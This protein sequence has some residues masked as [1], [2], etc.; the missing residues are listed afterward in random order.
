MTA[1]WPTTLPDSFTFESYGEGF[2]DGRLRSETDTGPGKIRLRSSAIPEPLSG[3]MKM[4]GAQIEILR[5][6]IKTTLVGGTLPFTFKSQRGGS[7]ILVRFGEDLPTWQRF[8][9]GL[10]LV[11]IKLEVLP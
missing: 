11:S 7:S 6:F 10:Y 4:T 2:G 1:A 5:L 9:T 8:A 3:Q